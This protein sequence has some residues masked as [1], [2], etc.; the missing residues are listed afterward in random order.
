MPNKQSWRSKRSGTYTVRGRVSPASAVTRG[1][2]D[3]LED[4][5]SNDKSEERIDAETTLHV[6]HYYRAHNPSPHFRYLFPCSLIT[7][8]RCSYPPQLHSEHRRDMDHIGRIYLVEEQ[9]ELGRAF[10]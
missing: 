10:T 2:L 6:F 1:G 5:P 9:L 7:R 3:D 4:S 8:I